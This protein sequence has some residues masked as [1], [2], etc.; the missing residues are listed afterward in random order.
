TSPPPPVSASIEQLMEGAGMTALGRRLFVA[1]RPEL[2]DADRL[3]VDCGIDAPAEP[4]TTHTFGCL[5]RGRIHVR[6]FAAPELRSLSYAVAAHELLHVVYVQLAPVERSRL[7]AQLA[8]A[9]AGNEL[10][11]DRLSIYAERGDDTLDEVHSLLGTEFPD[12]SPALEAHYARYFDRAKVLAAYQSTIGHRDAAM[13]ELKA[14]AE[15]LG[16]QLEALRAEMDALEA[17]G[18]IRGYNALVTT[19]NSVLREHNAAARQFNEVLAEYRRLL[20]A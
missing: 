10:L 8:A 19:Y 9:R 12:L 7:D 2:Q 16:R 15:E 3:A 5:V 13:R 14:R 18:D 17:A 1:A 20:A 4:G 11:E 6:S